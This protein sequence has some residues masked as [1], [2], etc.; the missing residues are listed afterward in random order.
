MRKVNDQTEILAGNPLGK[1]KVT[2]G[3]NHHI[4]KTNREHGDKTPCIKDFG[5][6]HR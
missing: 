5:T 1:Y 2:P 4:I 6:T 3:P